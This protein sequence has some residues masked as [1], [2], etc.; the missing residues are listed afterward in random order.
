MRGTGAL[1]AT[2]GLVAGVAIVIG[3]NLPAAARSVSFPT[4]SGSNNTGSL[5]GVKAQDL[6]AALATLGTSANTIGGPGIFSDVADQGLPVYDVETGA[7]PNVCI[8]VRNLSTAGDIKVLVA[9]ANEVVVTARRTRTS[10]YGAPTL[11]TLRCDL[12]PC[13]GVWRVDEQQ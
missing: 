13:A 7:P 8:T 3:Q 1:F 6:E 2:L 10:C 11:I 5:A 12:T 9:G 4:P